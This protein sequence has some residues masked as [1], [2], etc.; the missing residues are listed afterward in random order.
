MTGLVIWGA[1]LLAYAAFRRWYDG[2][3][4]PLTA[5]EIE[6]LLPLLPAHARANEQEMA[7]L[8]AFLTHDDGREFAMLNLVKLAP[9]PVPHPQSGEPMPAMQLLELYTR[10][11]FRALMRKASHPAIAARVIGGYLDSWNVPDDP[12]WSIIGYMRYR[13]RRDMLELITDPRFA[14]AHLFK[15]AATPV[16][17]SFPTAPRILLFVSP[18]VTVALVIALAAALLQLALG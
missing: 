18:R 9:E 8:R 14:N 13:S 17:L 11:F 16:T 2:R 5:Q 1:A 3:R 12:G 6:S 10:D 4:A 7:T 15:I